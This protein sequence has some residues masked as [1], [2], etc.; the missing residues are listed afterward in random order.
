MAP[1]SARSFL[2]FTPPRSGNTWVGWSWSRVIRTK[3]HFREEEKSQI[4]KGEERKVKNKSFFPQLF[5]HAMEFPVIDRRLQ[6]H[7]TVPVEMQ[8][9][10]LSP[11]CL[12]WAPD[13]LI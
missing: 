4:D 2:S 13:L 3:S 5:L 7:H 10:V 6:H 12:P 9:L 1:V 8:S 11:G